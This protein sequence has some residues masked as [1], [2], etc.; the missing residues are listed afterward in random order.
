[1]KY[2]STS[3]IALLTLIFVSSCSNDKPIVEAFMN[4]ENQAIEK[5][6]GACDG[7]GA[8]GKI[9]IE[10]PIFSEN[11]KDIDNKINAEITKS[12][13]SFYDV[14]TIKETSEL[15]IKDFA[16]FA[17]E[18]PEAG[19]N[20][21][22]VSMKYRVT[23]NTKDLLA[24]TFNMEG[25]TGGAHGFRTTTYTNYNPNTGEKLKLTDIVNDVD[26]LRLIARDTFIEEN[27]L[28]PS[29]SLN[30]QGFWFLDDIFALNNNFK[31]SSEGLTFFYNQYEIAPYSQGPIVINISIEKLEGLLK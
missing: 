13:S 23:T 31:I 5:S 29:E 4:L 15:F 26:K 20:K 1:M 24:L 12:I 18:F 28:D 27:D 30:T 10:Y 14:K 16:D 3:L 22:N 17:K 7:E 8:C 9:V 19:N 11:N 2:F 6:Y 25:Y 21:W